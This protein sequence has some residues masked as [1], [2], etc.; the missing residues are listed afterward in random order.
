MSDSTPIFEVR[1]LRVAIEGKEIL[2]GVDLTIERGKV[3]ALMGR[4]GSGKSTLAYVALGHPSYEV[5]EGQILYNGTDVTELNTDERARL[6]MFL[7]FQY[8]MAIPGVT[9]SKFMHSALKARAENGDV[10]LREFRDKLNAAMDLLGVDKS[11]TGRYV[12]DGFSGGEKKRLEILQM[13]MLDPTFCI[14]DETD[15]G[16]DIDAL[17]TVAEG[18]NATRSEERSHLV[19]THYQ[20]LLNYIAPDVVHVMMDGQIARTGGPELALQLEENGYEW[21]EDEL[22]Q[23]AGA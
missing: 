18:V 2:R 14:L 11:F 19:I 8:P 23:A 16:L 12:N 3:H 1:G 20:R 6:G 10:Q 21:L 13:F 15:S 17:K 9:V 4:N 7:A 22:L 5:L